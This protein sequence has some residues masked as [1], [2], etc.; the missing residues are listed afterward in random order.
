M[1]V[2]AV[3]ERELL[4]TISWFDGFVVALANPSFLITGLGGSV[5]SAGRLGRGDPVDD[6]RRHRRAA[7]LH[8][9]RDGGDV[10]QALGRH[11]D[12]R[13]RGV[14]EVL[15]VRR[16]G[17]RVRLLDRLVGGAVG[18][19]HRRRLP[20]PGPVVPVLG[21]VDVW[22]HSGHMLGPDPLYF[23]FPIALTIVIIASSGCSTCS[24][25]ARRSGSAT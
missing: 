12:L 3:E 9:L 19:R 11:R 20:G 4:K 5:L 2:A 22:N 17:R 6:V 13:P 23:S 1:A 7:Q 16:A 8:L 10:P 14:E 21:H 25:C 18:H 15:L 24:A